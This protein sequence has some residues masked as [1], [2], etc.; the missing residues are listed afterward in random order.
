MKKSHLMFCIALA[1]P[2]IAQVNL[3]QAAT[4]NVNAPGVSV[5]IG[6]RDRHGNYWDGYNWRSQQWWR[7]HQNKRIGER[8]SR[9]LYWHGNSW[10][11]A[12]PPNHGGRPQPHGQGDRPDMGNGTHGV[13]GHAPIPPTSGPHT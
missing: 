6:D 9:G 5:H 13:D 7:Q 4:V 11:S 8:N 1:L 3:A 10:S 12:P 2:A